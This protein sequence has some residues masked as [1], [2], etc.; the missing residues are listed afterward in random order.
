MGWMSN[1]T[2]S[3][4]FCCPVPVLG[5]LCGFLAGQWAMLR[6]LHRCTILGNSPLRIICGPTLYWVT[7]LL[8]R[9]IWSPF[10]LTDSVSNS[11]IPFQTSWRR[12]DPNRF[13]GESSGQVGL[14]G[15]NHDDR[16]GRWYVEFDVA[17]HLLRYMTFM[18]FQVLNRSISPRMPHSLGSCLFFSLFRSPSTQVPEATWFVPPRRSPNY[19]LSV[20]ISF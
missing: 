10:C 1:E 16:A 15:D 6:R 13:S 11:P 17:S 12:M 18:L 20:F 8:C 4:G 9:V 3:V 2:E 19:L 14:Q 7:L 5:F